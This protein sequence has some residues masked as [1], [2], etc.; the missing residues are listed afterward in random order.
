[1]RIGWFITQRRGPFNE[2]FKA[3]MDYEHDIAI[4]DS[5]DQCADSSNMRTEGVLAGTSSGCFAVSLALVH[6]PDRPNTALRGEVGPFGE[7]DDSV[8][9]LHASAQLRQ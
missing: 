4:G 1:M 8:G 9:G 2:R 3:N 7:D 5:G 6:P